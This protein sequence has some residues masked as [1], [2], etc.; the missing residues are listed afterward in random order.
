MD[1]WGSE[2]LISTENVPFGVIIAFAGLCC[3]RIFT[4][5][6]MGLLGLGIEHHDIFSA[7]SYDEYKSS[8]KPTTIEFCL[9]EIFITYKGLFVPPRSPRPLL[10]PIV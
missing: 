10:F 7:L 4:V 2:N 9:Y 3:W 1:I 8:F 6:S 5:A